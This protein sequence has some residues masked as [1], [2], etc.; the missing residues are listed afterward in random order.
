MYTLV[1]GQSR[2]KGLCAAQSSANLV[3]VVLHESRLH[4]NHICC[5]FYE[6]FTP[7][8]GHALEVLAAALIPRTR[9]VIPRTNAWP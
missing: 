9:K 6:V 8:G 4:F 5:C 2:E 1:H 3:F 7:D